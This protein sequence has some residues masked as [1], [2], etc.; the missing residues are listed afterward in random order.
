[1]SGF[2]KQHKIKLIW[3][4][5]VIFVGSTAI[6]NLTGIFNRSNSDESGGLNIAIVNGETILTESA[7]NAAQTILN[8]YISY[9]QQVNI[10]MND[11]TS[12]AKGALFLLDLRAQGLQRMIQEALFRQAAEERKIRVSKDEI[13]ESFTAQYN[14]VLSSNNLTEDQLESI[15]LE[16]RQQSLN[17]FKDSLRADVERQLR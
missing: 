12:G 5:V 3:A 13:N 17:D 8:Q 6:M 14:E 9:Y 16:Q 15:L 1:M 2:F 10:P 7:A 4:V 11:L